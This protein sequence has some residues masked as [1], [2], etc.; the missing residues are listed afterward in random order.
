MDSERE[1]A[2]YE[3]YSSRVLSYGLRHLRNKA[4]AEDLAQ[5]VLIVV[6][7][8]LREGR[9]QDVDNLDHYVFGTARNVTMEMRRGDKRQQRIADEN[10]AVLPECVEPRWA[11]A[12]APRLDGCLDHLEVR[13]RSVVLATFVDDRDADEIGR[14]MGLTAGNVRVV[15]HRALAHLR[16]CME[17]SVLQ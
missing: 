12:D 7:K 10:A 4:G 13:E 5:H 15:R 6:L 17:G 8:A 1:R 3:R 16:E 2:I 11:L 14:A 9:V